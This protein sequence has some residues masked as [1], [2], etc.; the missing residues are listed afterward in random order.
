[1]QEAKSL[2]RRA[3]SFHAN[4]AGR[5]SEMWQ[6]AGGASPPA[7]P[8]PDSEPPRLEPRAC[9]R[10]PKRAALLP[11]RLSDE[12]ARRSAIVIPWS[13]LA[14]PYGGSRVPRSSL[15]LQKKSRQHGDLG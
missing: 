15:A 13:R 2:C 7:S 1:V 6:E 8:L 10:Y 12:L 9:W 5:R 14:P 11:Q 4:A 3:F